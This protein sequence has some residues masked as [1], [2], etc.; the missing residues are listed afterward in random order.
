MNNLIAGYSSNTKQWEKLF[1]LIL[2]HSPTQQFSLQYNPKNCNICFCS[3]QD[4]EMLQKKYPNSVFIFISGEPDPI[5]NS[6]IP[7]ILDCKKI[8][9]YNRHQ[10]FMYLPFYAISF[11]E[12]NIHVPQS[13]IKSWLYN[14]VEILK[15]KTKFC[16]YMYRYDLPHRVKLF[17]E[18][19]KYKKVESLGKS[20]NSNPLY[21]MDGSPYDSA[22]EK[23]K[24]FKFVICCENHKIPGYVTEK[25][26]NAM[27]ANAIPIY[28][29]APD[30]VEHFNSKSFI[31]VSSF[32]NLSAM[33]NF[34]KQVDQNDDL[35]VSILK[36]PWLNDNKLNTYLNLKDRLKDFFHLI[37][38]VLKQSSHQSLSLSSPNRKLPFISNRIPSIRSRSN[39]PFP[40]PSPPQS[41][42]TS[43]SSPLSPSNHFLKRLHKRPLISKFANFSQ[44]QLL[45]RNLISRKSGSSKSNINETR[46]NPNFKL[47]HS[48]LKKKLK[49]LLK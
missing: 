32:P 30:I 2:K 26:V 47:N 44:Q 18:I 25:I 42:Q 28:F 36:E 11:V 24:P 6:K 49:I 37:E 15:T 20:K 33:T 41:N 38:T 43:P 16:A 17:D 12:R 21:Q 45:S 46:Q 14:P 9:Y 40:L 10:K 23:Y 19:S 27:L 39:R 34:I 4:A 7:I 29:G 3:Y 13:L 8:N 35:Y 48:L 5:K 1:D 31:N 22:V